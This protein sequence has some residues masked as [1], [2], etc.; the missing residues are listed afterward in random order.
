MTR[1]E[2]EAELRRR[3]CDPTGLSDAVVDW[4]AT[5]HPYWA[6]GSRGEG[7]RA[8]RE[9]PPPPP[10]DFA[11]LVMQGHGIAQRQGMSEKTLAA[12]ANI[13]NV[14]TSG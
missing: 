1:A 4:I 8:S 5:D 6:N 14:G 7:R 13:V 9:D 2:G 12:L 3:G 10:A 11:L